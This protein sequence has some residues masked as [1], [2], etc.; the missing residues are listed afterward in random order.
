MRPGDLKLTLVA[1]WYSVCVVR[2][3]HDEISRTR[4]AC[5]G[6]TFFFFHLKISFQLVCCSKRGCCSKLGF[7][8]GVFVPRVMWETLVK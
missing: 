1:L 5:G 2:L 8:V 6:P 3:Q 4:L 7:K